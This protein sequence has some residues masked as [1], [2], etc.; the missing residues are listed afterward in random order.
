MFV[1][2]SCSVFKS[3]QM[4]ISCTENIQA[5]LAL[6]E[7]FVNRDQISVRHIV[8]LAHI[9]FLPFLAGV[10]IV[11]NL[12]SL[13]RTSTALPAD[14]YQIGAIAGIIILV[15]VVLFLLAL[16]IIYRHKQKGK[17]SSMPA[18]TY[19]PAMRVMNADYAI[20]GETGLARG[21]SLHEKRDFILVLGNRVFG[22]AA[23]WYCQLAL[24][25]FYVWRRCIVRDVFYV[26]TVVKSSLFSLTRDLKLVSLYGCFKCWKSQPRRSFAG[27][28]IPSCCHMWGTGRGGEEAA[29]TSPRSWSRSEKKP[30]LLSL[31]LG[32]SQVPSSLSWSP[33]TSLT[34]QQPSHINS[35]GG[36]ATTK[37]VL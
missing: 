10:I 11:G 15:L 18:V 5:L 1:L 12:N 32:S 6:W 3:F 24:S 34:T 2:P 20:S 21:I 36:L 8:I 33:C 13:S 9:S 37:A 7:I 27:C 22:C 28:L 19:T 16:F 17:E 26:S 30:G 31:A 4:K 29:I 23:R 25:S 35:L 14:S